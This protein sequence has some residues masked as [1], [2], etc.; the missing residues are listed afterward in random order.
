[1][2]AKLIISLA[3][4]LA[5]CGAQFTC[6]AA[7]MDG[8]LTSSRFETGVWRSLS[9][10]ISLDIQRVHSTLCL[11]DTGAELTFISDRFA[12]HFPSHFMCHNKLL[13]GIYGVGA[14]MIGYLYICFISLYITNDVH[15][16]AVV[17]VP[18]LGEA[19]FTSRHKCILG[20]STLEATQAEINF[21]CGH[22]SFVKG[23]YSEEILVAMFGLGINMDSLISYDLLNPNITKNVEEMK[24]NNEDKYILVSPISNLARISS[25]L[26]FHRR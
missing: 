11:V 17:L 6:P 25:A 3:F 15:S 20:F 26:Q 1:M 4:L 8:N 13:Q 2:L 22:I 16:S 5:F 10:A 24:I 12:H 19:A 14:Q 21:R 18:P 9:I 7:G 23:N